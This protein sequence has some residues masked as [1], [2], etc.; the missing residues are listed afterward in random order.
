MVGEH[1]V[2]SLTSL[3]IASAWQSRHDSSRHLSHR[4][5]TPPPASRH[6]PRERLAVRSERF[7]RLALHR[8][9]L[10]PHL[11]ASPHS[12]RLNDGARKQ[13]RKRFELDAN[14]GRLVVD[15]R[16]GSGD[17]QASSKKV[18]AGQVP[19][20]VS[21]IKGA[22]ARLSHMVLLGELVG[23]LADDGG[24]ENQGDAHLDLMKPHERWKPV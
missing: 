6:S 22:S 4:I 18:L 11:L 20:I 9:G 16:V 13:M 24:H 10:S 5:I 17:Q 23:K 19:D 7:E 15:S 1:R 3:A 12:E 21:H 14:T 8:E 2:H